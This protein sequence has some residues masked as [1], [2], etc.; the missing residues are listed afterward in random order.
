MEFMQSSLASA[1]PVVLRQ[2]GAL[3]ITGGYKLWGVRCKRSMVG[4]RGC[5]VGA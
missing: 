4:G 2:V 3:F 1:V 5:E